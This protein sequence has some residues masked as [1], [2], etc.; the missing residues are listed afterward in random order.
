MDTSSLLTQLPLQLN[1]VLVLTL[2]AIGYIIKNTPAFHKVSNDVI[3]IVLPLVSVAIC[4]LTRTG[5][6]TDAVMG[7][8]INAAFAVWAHQTGKN[9][10]NLLPSGYED[11][12]E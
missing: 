4:I 3:P 6:M 10:F 7:G 5:T 11:D 2:F 8:I 9:I 1:V 12:E